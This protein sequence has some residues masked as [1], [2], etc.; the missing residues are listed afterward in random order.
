[1]FFYVQLILHYIYSFLFGQCLVVLMMLLLVGFIITY[2]HLGLLVLFVIEFL[3]SIVHVCLCY[4]MCIHPSGPT[5]TP[6]RHSRIS[7]SPTSIEL[8]WTSI[9]CLQ[10]NGII[11]NFTI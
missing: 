1:M 9:E 2:F 4:L 3:L 7:S 6:G 11:T 8:T 10:Q 5:G